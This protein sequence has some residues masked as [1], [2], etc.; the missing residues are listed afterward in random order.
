[1]SAQPAHSPAPAWRKS[2]ASADQGECVEVWFRQSEVLI[3][4][5][6]NKSGA[7]LAV[8]T[9]SWQELLQRIKNGELADS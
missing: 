9:G 1:M 2:R 7:V 8:S 3:R 6:R 4:D 5:S